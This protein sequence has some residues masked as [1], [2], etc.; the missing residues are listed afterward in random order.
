MVMVLLYEGERTGGRHYLDQARIGRIFRLSRQKTGDRIRLYKRAHRIED[1]LGRERRNHHLTPSMV[2]VIHGMLLEDPFLGASE[3]RRRLCE[4]GHLQRA[5]DI[6]LTTVTEAIKCVDYVAVRWKIEEML[7]RGTLVPDYQ[8][9]SQVLLEE[10]NGLAKIAGKKVGQRIIPIAQLL[11]PNAGSLSPPKVLTRSSQVALEDLMGPE[12]GT[13]TLASGWRATFIHYF[14]FGASYRELASFLGVH[15]STVYRRLVSIRSR[16]PALAKVL[17]PLRFSGIVGIDEKY[18]LAPKPHREGKMA[19]WAY[20]PIAIDPYSYDLLHAEVYPARSADCARAFLVGLKASG[21]LKPKAIVTD[22]WGPYES[23]IHQDVPRCRTSP[24]RVPR[25][26]GRVHDDA[27]QVGQGVS[28]HPGGRDPLEGHRRRV[29]GRVPPDADPAIREARLA[30]GFAPRPPPRLGPGVRVA[31]ASLREAG[32]RLH[33]SPALDPAHEQRDGA[34]LP[35]LHPPVQDAG[36]LRDTRNGAGIREALVLVL[37]VPPVL[38]RREPAHPQQE[39][40]P[41]RGLR[42]PRPDVP[43]PRHAAP[44]SGTALLSQTPCIFPIAPARG[45]APPA[46]KAGSRAVSSEGD[47]DGGTN[48]RATN[49]RSVDHQRNSRPRPIMPLRNGP[50]SRERCASCRSWPAPCADRRESGHSAAGYASHGRPR[51][52]LTAIDSSPGAPVRAAPRPARETARL[53]AR[54]AR[55]KGDRSPR[56][57]G[58]AAIVAPAA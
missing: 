2:A 27:R 50:E 54:D 34:G 18:I 3:I 15:A 28:Q 4:Q 21:V 41:D 45:R 56:C 8:K 10:M 52:G 25:G 57:W 51:D 6:G 7:K 9:I 30:E 43:R 33:R 20:L 23:V 22:L 31:C 12:P 40:A 49:S 24:V 37:P 39:P 11:E 44:S 48:A 32:Q 46:R 58:N 55:A 19:R 35:L 13:G 1:V 17:G 47:R 38:T 42:G 26:A 16:L 5:D 36:G 53:R 29:P 14:T